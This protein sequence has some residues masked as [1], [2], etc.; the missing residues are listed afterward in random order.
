[1]NTPIKLVKI[2]SMECRPDAPF[3]TPTERFP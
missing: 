2:L 3:D 1:M